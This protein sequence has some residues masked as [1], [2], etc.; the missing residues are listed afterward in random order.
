MGEN[1]GSQFFN[2]LA[3]QVANHV[4]NDW[5]V[6]L[7]ALKNENNQLK[8]SI[9]ALAATVSDLEDCDFCDTKFDRPDD[10][11]YVCAVNDAS[12]C[13]VWCASLN[14]DDGAAFM[15]ICSHC[16]YGM[17]K[18]HQKLCENCDRN[19]CYTCNQYECNQ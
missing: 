6:K 3:N 18:D 1:V 16:G 5:K 10:Y 12:E 8:I 7:N 15:D 9:N 14:C 19:H 11:H 17:C 4:N 13:K 2:H